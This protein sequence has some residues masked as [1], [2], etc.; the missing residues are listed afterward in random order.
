MAMQPPLIVPSPQLSPWQHGAVRPFVGGYVD[1]GV[2]FARPAIELG[3]GQPHW[4]WFGVE[5]YALTTSGFFA[6]YAG[7][8]ASLPVLD[9]TLGVR[10]T[11]SYARAFLPPQRRF[12]ADDL[13]RGGEPH[14]RYTAIDF[15]LDGIVPTPVGYVVADIL[16]TRLLDLP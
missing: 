12:A 15:E 4:S 2:V 1:A 13:D 3:Y 5:A 6:T 10:D 9:V 7:T 14:A 16:A 11:W 8:R